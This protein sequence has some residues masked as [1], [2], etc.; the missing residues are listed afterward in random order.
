MLKHETFND[1]DSMIEAAEFQR[2]K[3]AIMDLGE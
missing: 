3:D 1:L 2:Q